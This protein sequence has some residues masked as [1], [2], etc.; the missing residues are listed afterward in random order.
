MSQ[1]AR[2]VGKVEC[3]EGEGGNLVIRPGPCEVQRTPLD[4]TISWTDGLSK[5]AAAMPLSDFQRYV[6]GHAIRF[7]DAPA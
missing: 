4:A 7:D 5:G 3:R 6:S 1:S 2:I